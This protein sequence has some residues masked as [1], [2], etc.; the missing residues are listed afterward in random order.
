MLVLGGVERPGDAKR[1]VHR[2]LR[3]E[4]QV[5]EDVEHRALGDQRRPEGVA[6]AAVPDRFGQDPPH[7]SRATEQRV[8]AGP[9]DLLDHDRGSPAL[10]AEDPGRQP[11]E[12]DLARG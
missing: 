9:D 1:G 7:H 8:Q 10:L 4:R 6:V 11:E 3:F 2:R 5:G 12:L